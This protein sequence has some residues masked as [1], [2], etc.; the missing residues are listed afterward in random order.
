MVAT[1]RTRGAKR[2]VL[3]G[4]CAGAW[5]AVHTALRTKVDGVIAINPQLYWDVGDPVE[6][7]LSDTRKRR[8]PIRER[9]KRLEKWWPVLDAIGIRPPAAH[10]LSGLTRTHTPSLLL[11]AQGDDGIEYLE[12]RVARRLELERRR[13]FIKVEQI[14]D[15]DHQ[16][17]RT[18]RR[19]DVI[20][21]LRRT[22]DGL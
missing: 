9:D 17:Y 20:A 6:A 8:E 3:A 7:L 19:P 12:M 18:W 10:W 4:L 22:L 2:V 15:I 16:M 21:T 5:M 1:L 14:P 11:F 13:G